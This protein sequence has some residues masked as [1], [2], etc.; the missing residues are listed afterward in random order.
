MIFTPADKRGAS[1]KSGN[2]C[3]SDAEPKVRIRLPP[4]KSHANRRFLSD[5]AGMAREVAAFNLPVRVGVALWANLQSKPP[6]R[7]E[8]VACL[9]HLYSRSSLA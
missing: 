7:G 5:G 8:G 3:L 2:R 4:E 1:A 6:A 9:D